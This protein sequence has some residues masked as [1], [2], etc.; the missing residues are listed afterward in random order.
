MPNVLIFMSDEHNPLV[1]SVYGHPLVQTPNMERLAA[2]G[3]VFQH[4][5]CPSPL[6]LPSRSAFMAGKPVHQLQ[7]YNNCNVIPFNYPSY[8]GVLARQGVYTV[9]AGKMDVYNH[10]STMGFCEL[11][12]PGDRAQ[13]GDTHISRQPLAIR[14]DGPKRAAGFGP[15]P[16]PF[17]KD[18]AVVDEAVAWLRERAPRMRQPWVLV[19]NTG[20]PHFPH[21]VTPELWER[22]EAGADLPPYGPEA[23]PGQHPYACD[24]RRHFQTEA[25]TEEQL[26]GLRRGYLGRV[27]YVDQE[28]GRLLDALEASGQAEE[29][30][31]AYT[32]DHGEMLGK[33]GLWWKCSL[34]EDSVRVPLI[35]AGPGFAAGARVQTPVSLL[36]LQASLFAATGARRPEDWWGRPLQEVRVDD[37]DRVVLAEYHGHGT[38]SGAFMVRQGR[39]KLIY[40]LAAPHQLFD[41]ATDPDE[42]VNRASEEP[43]VLARLERA[44][45]RL[46]DPEEENRRAHQFE[47]EQ[48]RRLARLAGGAAVGGEAGA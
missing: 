48:L 13:P 39:W 47:Q 5:Y 20:A 11:L 17:A 10:S 40:N 38:R 12:R 16:H 1:S 19:V 30:V 46:C 27:T 44:L 32:S 35:V 36:D 26:R 45:R 42:L 8:G 14:R 28:L 9:Y 7:T 31:V 43:E 24:L 22:Y 37:P 6:C 34:Y 2:R 33:F 4:A 3:T 18:Q 25:F 23:P 21:Y 15:R 29:T 41:L